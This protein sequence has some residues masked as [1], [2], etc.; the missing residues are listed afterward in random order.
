MAN[1]C[2]GGCTYTDL[3][4]FITERSRAANKVPGPVLVINNDLIVDEIQIARSAAVKYQGAMLALDILGEEKLAE[5][6]KAARARCRHRS[7]CGSL[8]AHEQAQTASSLN[9]R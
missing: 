5:F 4:D 3:Q 7:Y 2:M 6:I 8:S 1:E 9:R